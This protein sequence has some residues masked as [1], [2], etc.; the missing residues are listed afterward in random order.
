MIQKLS[1]GGVNSPVNSTSY[2]NILKYSLI[3]LMVGVSA[4][5]VEA[6]IHQK[7]AATSSGNTLREVNILRTS[8]I[9]LENNG[10]Q[11]APLKDTFFKRNAVL[12]TGVEN[13]IENLFYKDVYPYFLN[14]NYEIC[15][16]RNSLVDFE[17]EG[18]TFMPEDSVNQFCYQ[19]PKTLVIKNS[20]AVGKMLEITIMGLDETKNTFVNQ[21]DYITMPIKDVS[22]LI[23]SN[24][25]TK[26]KDTCD[27]KSYYSDIKGLLIASVTTSGVATAA[28]AAGTALNVVETL[29]ER[30]ATEVKNGE[31]KTDN[32]KL[33][34]M[35]IAEIAL[36]GTA[37]ATSMT[38]AITNFVSIEKINKLSSQ[39]E[40]CVDASKKLNSEINNI[41]AEVGD[42]EDLDKYKNIVEKCS[43]L[44]GQDKNIKTI[45]S[46]A[47]ASGVTSMVG[48]AASG[49][50]IATTVI[51]SKDDKLDND[52]M[53]MA[54]TI[55]SGIGASTGVAGTTLNASNL[56]K[57]QDLIGELENCTDSI[58]ELEK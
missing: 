49:A 23:S 12:Y 13:N 35:N 20:D 5:S 30:K 52:K 24:T 11:E 55:T 19:Q 14:S 2:K 9:Q 58:S 28:G 54:S 18:G 50:S 21:M 26:V 32:K 7:R 3:A 34:G 29:N 43:S 4:N 41:Y 46:L 44:S 16:W 6:R 38:S 48:A 8:S 25:L 47:T 22:S 17:V 40:K 42:G 1:R 51:N 53:N 10:I 15:F 39:M 56:A 27:F 31:E 36:S 57:I 37:A 45:K 33:S